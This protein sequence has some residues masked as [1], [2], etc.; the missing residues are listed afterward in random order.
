MLMLILTL[1]NANA[2]AFK[3][4][5]KLLLEKFWIGGFFVKFMKIRRD[6]DDKTLPWA[7]LS[8]L[9]ASRAKKMFRRC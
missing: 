2:R 5:E 7:R 6:C 1:S 4:L 3:I 8:K 9:K